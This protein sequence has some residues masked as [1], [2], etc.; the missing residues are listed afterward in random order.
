MVSRIFC[1]NPGEKQHETPFIGDAPFSSQHL[2]FDSG[3]YML[4]RDTAQSLRA[5]K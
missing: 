4:S 2:S 1:E 3:H 5:R